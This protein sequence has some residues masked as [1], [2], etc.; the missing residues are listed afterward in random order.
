MCL[1]QGHNIVTTVRLK[2]AVPRSRVKHSTTEPLCFHSVI[3]LISVNTVL[4][5]VCESRTSNTVDIIG[6]VLT[7][8]KV[9]RIGMDPGCLISN[10]AFYHWATVH[11]YHPAFYKIVWSKPLCRLHTWAG[12]QLWAS[13]IHLMLQLIYSPMKQMSNQHHNI[14]SGKRMLLWSKQEEREF[15]ML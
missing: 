8:L 12:S 1:A 4:T 6:H 10:L 5:L 11:L 14:F 2:P 13:S 9:T 15:L 3:E 7:T